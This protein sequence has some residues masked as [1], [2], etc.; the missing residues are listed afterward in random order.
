M[1][2]RGSIPQVMQQAG[3]DMLQP[4]AGIPWVR[5]EL[6]AGGSTGEVVVA[7]ALGI[8]TEER[9]P[10]GGLEI[11]TRQPDAG[12]MTGLVA[13]M[14]IQRPLTITATLDP[15]KQPFLHDHEIDG[16]SVLPGVMGIEAFAEASLWPV[17]GWH[18]RVI[19]DV[20]FLAPFKFYRKEPRQVTTESVLHPEGDGLVAHCRLM[21]SRTL[22]NQPEPQV[23]C[24][25]AARVRLAK[26]PPIPVRGAIPFLPHGSSIE[27]A[28]LYRV[29][30]HGPAYQVVE[31]AWW[32]EHRIVAELN[33]KLPP[34]HLP[35]HLP[36]T[37]S[38]RLIELCFQAAGVWEMAL[39]QRMGLPLHID[40]VSLLRTADSAV[41]PLYA[42]VTAGAN[43]GSFD[44]EVVD[45]EGN[46]YVSLSGYR[47]AE[48]GIVKTLAPSISLQGA[49]V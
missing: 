9:D 1:A 11:I 23:T 34:N 18:I 37:A 8:L 49:G 6:T 41:G 2:T 32:D 17:P 19:E 46:C 31:R 42:V 14:G 43:P 26:E 15:T 5:R 39:Q 28:D 20:E 21:G 35:G 44:A 12:P 29:Y 25:F 36:L 24:H 27:R 45:A 33:S 40:R 38:P 13:G 47:S 10:L 48:F 7:Q 16:T 30:F 4:E 3:I 22:V